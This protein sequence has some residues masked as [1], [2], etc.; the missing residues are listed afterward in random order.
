ML[1]RLVL[2][3]LQIIGAYFIGKIVMGYIPIRGDLSIFVFAVV[4]SVIIFLIGIVASQI[5]K[6]VGM[7]HSGTLSSSLV[8]ALIFALIWTFVPPLVPGLPWS[9]VPDQWAVIIG[10]V[11][12]TSRN[13]SSLRPTKV[14]SAERGLPRFSFWAFALCG[15]VTRSKRVSDHSEADGRDEAE[16]QTCGQQI[17]RCRNAHSASLD[18]LVVGSERACPQRV[19]KPSLL[20]VCGLLPHTATVGANW[21]ARNE[22]RFR[23]AAAGSA[24]GSAHLRRTNRRRNASVTPF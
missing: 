10:A 23:I 22:K 13:A 20:F 8:L 12:V 5:I 3:L 7:P 15:A 4:V 21:Q 14:K 6:D 11:L 24:A 18:V 16:R 9:K 2:L 17:E 1:G 19:P